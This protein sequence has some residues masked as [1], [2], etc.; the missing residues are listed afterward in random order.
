MTTGPRDLV[1]EQQRDLVTTTPTTLV[2]WAYAH[3]RPM[4]ATAG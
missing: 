4:L 1:P 2:A 3:L